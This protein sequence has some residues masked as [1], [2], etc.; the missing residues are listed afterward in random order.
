MRFVS[1]CK[2]NFDNLVSPHRNELLMSSLVETVFI[3]FHTEP[4]MSAAT[5]R[6]VCHIN[7]KQHGATGKEVITAA[8]VCVFQN[9]HPTSKGR[10]SIK[11]R[12]RV[13]LRGTSA[14]VMGVMSH[15]YYVWSP[16]NNRNVRVCVYFAATG[17]GGQLGENPAKKDRERPQQC[18]PGGC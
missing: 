1:T 17:G 2:F 18:C 8:P 15:M 16:H 5:W 9:T 14:L 6:M 3:S 11:V 4:V 13:E 10:T 12:I 7:A